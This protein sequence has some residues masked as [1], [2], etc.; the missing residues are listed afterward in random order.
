MNEQMIEHVSRANLR[1]LALSYAASNNLELEPVQDNPQAFWI[2]NGGMN[3][4]I[5]FTDDDRLIVHRETHSGGT[6]EAHFALRD[7]ESAFEYLSETTEQQEQNTAREIV[8]S[9]YFDLEGDVEPLPAQR[10]MLEVARLIL[11]EYK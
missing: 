7:F 4:A 8:S 10:I 3:E 9:M 6:R 2:A 5:E 11:E 1:Q